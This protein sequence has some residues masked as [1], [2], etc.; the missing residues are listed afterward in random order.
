MNGGGSGPYPVA[1][2]GVRGMNI[3]ALLPGSELA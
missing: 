3:L 2:F 1:S